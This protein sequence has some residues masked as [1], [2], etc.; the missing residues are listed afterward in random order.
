MSK[1]LLIYERATPVS[2]NRHR[3]WSVAQTRNFSF[4]RDVNAVPL[5][6]A[7]ILP[8]S[9]EFPVVFAGQDDDLMPTALLSV[10]DN[11]NAFVSEDGT[12]SGRYV[13]AFLRRYPFVFS[14]STGEDGDQFTLCVDEEYEGLNHEG[15]G[16]RLFDTS[17]DRTQ[18]LENTL[19][20]VTQYQNQ[21]TATEVFT[22]KLAELDLFEPAQ[23][24]FN[25]AGGRNGALGGFVRVS[26]EKLRALGDDVLLE[27]ARS[28]TMELIHAHIASLANVT[29]LAE[30]AAAGPVSEEPPAAE[31][32]DG[33]TEPADA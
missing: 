21:F 14:K 5:V 8:A 27:M 12:W 11:V 10:T 9:R 24:R 25:L 31:A 17:G 23:V 28:D 33:D 16:E 30:M 2:S 7:E 26:R 3:D 22:K 15:L 20:F 6:A 29:Q 13:P 1:Q 32:T 18:Y 4:A 19:N